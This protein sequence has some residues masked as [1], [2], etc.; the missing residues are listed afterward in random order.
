MKQEQIEELKKLSGA[1]TPQPWV[2]STAAELEDMEEYRPHI[3]SVPTGM[4]VASVL[5]SVDA[6]P[7][8]LDLICAMRN[9]LPTLLR[10][11][12]Q[13]LGALRAERDR[14]A[15]SV[16]AGTETYCECTVCRQI[17]D[18]IAAAES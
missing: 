12:E 8:N 9:A 16:A 1:A 10:E 2:P 13:L 17:R 3:R 15:A 6:Y 18:A 11:R 7:E 4:W 5:D 14:A